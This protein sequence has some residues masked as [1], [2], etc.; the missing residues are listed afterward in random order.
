M[1]SFIHERPETKWISWPWSATTLRGEK[2]KE[3]RQRTG[4]DEVNTQ[5][6]QLGHQGR[7]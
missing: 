7:G 5:V 3:E 1:E 6:N 2:G 4:K